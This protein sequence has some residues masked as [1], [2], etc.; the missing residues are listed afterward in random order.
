MLFSNWDN[1]DARAGRGG[2]NTGEFEVNG[3]RLAAFTDWGSG[4]GKW[5]S[6]P[7]SNS[8]WN[9]A[10][11]TAQ[12][13]LFVAKIDQK[14]VV[15]GWEGAINEGFRT[16]IPPEHVAWLLTSLGQVSDAQLR[17]WVKLAGG[18]DADV[19]CF[20]KALRSRID[21]LRSATEVRP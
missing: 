11:F 5:G 3:K 4:M 14:E 15:F 20:S 16:G 1:K 10:D 8:N 21:R 2:P 7:G 13:P 17:E 9:C 18:S 6:V 12:T 19:D